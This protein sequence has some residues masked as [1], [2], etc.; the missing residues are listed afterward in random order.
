M[1]LWNMKE[2]TE[3]VICALSN[4]IPDRYRQRLRELGFHVDEKI[5]C[6]KRTFAGG[7]RLYQVGNCV[8]SLEK[9]IAHAIEVKIQ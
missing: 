4:D 9:D 6:V 7:P 8:Y 5:T 3:A 1:Q 2:K